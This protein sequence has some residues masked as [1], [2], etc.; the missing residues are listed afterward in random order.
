MSIPAS[1][2]TALPPAAYAQVRPTL[3]SGDLLFCSGSFVFS[4]LIQRATGSPWSHVAIIMRLD[5]ID[6]LM[7]LE[8]VESQGVRTV[9]LSSYLENYSASGGGYPGKI[10]VA[11]H[12]GFAALA[13]QAG[14]RRMSQVAVDRF[15]YPYDRDEIARIA[16]RI[17]AGQLGWT[18]E[19]G[20]LA[21][22]EEYICSEYV[23]L[24]YQAL[25]LKVPQNNLGFIAPADFAAD[26]A[27]TAVC[28]LQ[29][30]PP[31][32]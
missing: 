27:V 7:V 12:A 20:D 23:D 30:N 19:D 21:P 2:F 32:G 5:A 15:G 3:Q 13:D 9:P 22:D 28:Q 26:P 18:A 11:R 14:L 25:G 4:R 29:P 6:R 17:V 16:A 8:S 1:V 10:V 24:C 31:A